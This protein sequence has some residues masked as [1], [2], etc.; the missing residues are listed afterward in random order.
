MTIAHT[1]PQAVYPTHFMNAESVDPNLERCGQ[2]QA[3]DLG[4][5]FGVADDNETR[6]GRRKSERRGK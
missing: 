1:I 6:K 2:L 5:G 3:T 4:L